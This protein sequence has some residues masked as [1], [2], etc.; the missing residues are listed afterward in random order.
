MHGTV[1]INL[2]IRAEMTETCEHARA[3]T[4]THQ[5]CNI[6]PRAGQIQSQLTGC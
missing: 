1:N 5:S 3:R 4:H 2:K 6:V